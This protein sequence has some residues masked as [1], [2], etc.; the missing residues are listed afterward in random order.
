MEQL[1]LPLYVTNSIVIGVAS[2]L[3]LRTKKKHTTIKPLKLL[4]V[5]KNNPNQ[6]IFVILWVA[7][8]YF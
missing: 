8:S 3:F 7:F 2:T 1:R 5:T 4:K 6:E